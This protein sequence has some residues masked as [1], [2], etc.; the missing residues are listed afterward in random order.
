MIRMNDCND[1]YLYIVAC[2]NAYIGV[3]NAEKK[4]F[5]ISRS[6]FGRN[7]EFVEYHWDTGEPHGTARPQKELFR[8]EPFLGEKEF[9]D[10]M[11][12]YYNKNREEIWSAIADDEEYGRVVRYMMKQAKVSSKMNDGDAA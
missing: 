12:E 1:G 3:Y 11:N 6:K 2:R 4:G 10:F 8:P 7:Y 5:R 9:L